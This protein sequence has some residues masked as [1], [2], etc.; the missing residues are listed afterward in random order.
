MASSIAC[1]PIEIDLKLKKEA[2]VLQEK[3]RT[4]NII[5]DKIASLKVVENYK[6][7]LKSVN[8]LK[9]MKEDAKNRNVDIDK[10]VID[11]LDE[12]M[13]RL[14]AERN[15]RFQLDNIDV[16]NCFVADVNELQRLMDIATNKHVD[17][18][19][20]NKAKELNSKMSR[21]I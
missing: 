5:L 8:Q 12:T 21:S 14:V 19:Y 9:E 16:G 20:M 13:E 1:K 2:I 7:I 18:C 4:Q 3:L 11:K 6:T 15:L 10:D 17:E